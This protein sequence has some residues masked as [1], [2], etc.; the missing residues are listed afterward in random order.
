[1]RKQCK[2]SKIKN[3]KIAKKNLFEGDS[4]KGYVA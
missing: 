1:M 4:L 2:S 3:K